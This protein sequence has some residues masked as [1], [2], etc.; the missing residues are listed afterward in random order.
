MIEDPAVNEYVRS[1]CLRTFVVLV[2]N[3]KL[4]REPV[5]DCFRSLFQ[6]RL[7]REPDFI[8]SALH[9]SPALVI[10]IQRNFCTISKRRMTMG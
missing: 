7:Q 5:V 3:E 4:P 8:L 10:C 9:S 2:A 1:A 6:A